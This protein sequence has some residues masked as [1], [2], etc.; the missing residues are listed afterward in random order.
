MSQQLM[1]RDASIASLSGADQVADGQN[2]NRQFVAIE[3]TG[4]ANVTVNFCGPATAGSGPGGV[5]NAAAPGGTGVLTIVPNGSIVLDHVV[6]QNP[7]VVRGTA[8]QPVT[9]VIA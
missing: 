2:G 7:I 3:N 1:F 6:P 5:G 8:G 9:I 4:N